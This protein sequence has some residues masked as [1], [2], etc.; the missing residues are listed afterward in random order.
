MCGPSPC[1]LPSCTWSEAHRAACE[2]RRVMAW[3]AEERKAYYAKVRAARGHD[4]AAALI[5][6]V[7][8][9]WRKKH[10]TY[11]V[12]YEPRMARCRE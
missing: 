1:S 4:A 7:N 10:G 9:E 5:A 8:S 2:A 12:P 6:D 11:E 3:P